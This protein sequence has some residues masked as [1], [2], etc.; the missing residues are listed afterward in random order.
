MRENTGEKRKSEFSGKNENFKIHLCRFPKQTGDEICEQ[1][2][3]R[4]ILI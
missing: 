3:K 4:K 2:K 1:E